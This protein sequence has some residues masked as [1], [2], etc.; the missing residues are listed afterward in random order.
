[1]LK[2]YS[3]NSITTIE[4]LKDLTHMLC[5]QISCHKL[6]KEGLFSY[7]LTLKIHVSFWDELLKFELKGKT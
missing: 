1:M 5:L 3:Y 2:C 4:Q 6:Y 7:V